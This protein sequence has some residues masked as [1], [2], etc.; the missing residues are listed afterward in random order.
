MMSKLAQRNYKED[1]KLDENS[2]LILTDASQKNFGK[3][4]FMNTTLS[5]MLGYLVN[6]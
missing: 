2:G 4:L 1:Y 3:I 6:N 5:K